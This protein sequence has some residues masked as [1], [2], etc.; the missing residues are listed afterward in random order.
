MNKNGEKALSYISTNGRQ[1]W[2]RKSQFGSHI[3]SGKDHLWMQK[4]SEW[5]F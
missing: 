5:M 4:S 2:I 3:V 1:S